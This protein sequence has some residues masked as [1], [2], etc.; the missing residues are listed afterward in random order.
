MAQKP[1]PLP[2]LKEDSDEAWKGHLLDNLF[3]VSYF[4]L[5]N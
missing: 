1:N 5:I 2:E 3:S 4:I